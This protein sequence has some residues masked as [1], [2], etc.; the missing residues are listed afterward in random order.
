MELDNDDEEDEEG[1][2]K[3]F[4]PG[5]DKLEK[6]EILEMDSA[7]YAMIHSVSLEWS[8]LS[9]DIIS[10]KLGDQRTKVCSCLFVYV[11]VC[12]FF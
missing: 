12:L 10:D 11:H 4:L 1:N 5:I 7:A 2:L 6:D 3:P 9:F 8:A